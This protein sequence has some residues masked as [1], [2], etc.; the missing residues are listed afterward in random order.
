MAQKETQDQANEIKSHMPRR[1][2]LLP[3]ILAAVLVLLMFW[4][5]YKRPPAKANRVLIDAGLGRFPDSAENLIIERK[6]GLLSTQAIF[7]GFHAAETD[8]V[9]FVN[10]GLSSTADEPGSLGGFHLGPQFSSWMKWD[11]EASGRVYHFDR[12]RTSTWLAIDDESDA[13][14]VYVFHHRGGW[15]NRLKSYLPFVR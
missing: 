12:G 8:V 4:N 14:Y 7:I 5:V 1:K 15:L 3:G 2:Y 6:G 11:A 10:G 9:R 13:I